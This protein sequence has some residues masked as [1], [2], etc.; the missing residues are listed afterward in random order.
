M[1]CD[2]YFVKTFFNNGYGYRRNIIAI[3]YYYLLLYLYLLITEKYPW[4]TI[5][6][7]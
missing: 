7:R 4:A 2:F 5:K 3:D 1:Y 6:A